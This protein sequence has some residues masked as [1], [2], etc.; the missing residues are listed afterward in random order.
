MPHV[1]CARVPSHSLV[2]ISQQLV[3]R[4]QKSL[5]KSDLMHL[6]FCLVWD[7]ESWKNNSVQV[8]NIWVEFLGNTIGSTKW[9][10][11][12]AHRKPRYNSTMLCKVYSLDRGRHEHISFVEF[13][14]PSNRDVW[15]WRCI[16]QLTTDQ[17]TSRLIQAVCETWKIIQDKSNINY[18]NA[19]QP[20]SWLAMLMYFKCMLTGALLTRISKP[21]KNL[22]SRRFRGGT[23]IQGHV[24]VVE[25][26]SNVMFRTRKTLVLRKQIKLS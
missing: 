25:H 6:S 11:F 17:A 9:G 23:Y 5:Q 1:R 20:R 24:S 21:P 4:K 13:N 8:N 14:E 26:I 18:S 3:L 2:T 15:H 22:G 16:V 7:R 10:F 12:F 19:C